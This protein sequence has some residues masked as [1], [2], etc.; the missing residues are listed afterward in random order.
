MQLGQVNYFQIVRNIEFNL[1]FSAI[2]TAK[3]ISRFV[4]LLK[5]FKMN[6]RLISEGIMSEKITTRIKIPFRNELYLNML[7]E[8]SFLVTVN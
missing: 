1:T 6:G 7:I 3:N 4:Q 5:G 2:N 8:K